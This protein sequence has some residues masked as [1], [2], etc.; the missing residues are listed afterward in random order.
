MYRVTIIYNRPTDTAA[1]DEYYQNKHL[2]LVAKIPNLTR[3]AAGKC[4]ALDA[5]PPAAY[6]LAQLYFDSKDQAGAAFASTE[7]QA[8]AADVGNFASGGVKMLFSDE[9]T[10]LP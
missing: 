1:F 6:A 3:F 9:E 4:E 10:T 8:A 5:N 2:P 7:G